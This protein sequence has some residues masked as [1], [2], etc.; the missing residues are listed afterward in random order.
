MV[1]VVSFIV[2]FEAVAKSNEEFK[3]I[4]KICSHLLMIIG[5][6][7][8]GYTSK[9]A[10]VEYKS[11]GL[12]DTLIVFLIPLILSILYLP[13]AYFFAIRS[14]YEMI[15]FKS[16]MEYEFNEGTKKKEEMGNI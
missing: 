2:L 13:I 10:I 1:P 16:N 3:I 5:F 12:I 15:F 9:I 11:L 8:I 6:S 4:E 14:K 7:L